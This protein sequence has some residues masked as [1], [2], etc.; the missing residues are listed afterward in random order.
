MKV[1]EHSRG[2]TLGR[3]L[4]E[5]GGIFEP[6]EGDDLGAALAVVLKK[7]GGRGAWWAPGIFKDDVRRGD[8]WRGAWTLGIDGDYYAKGLGHSPPSDDTRKSLVPALANVLAGAL[9]H[10]TPRGFRTVLLLDRCTLDKEEHTKLATAIQRRV[11]RGLADAGVLGVVRRVAGG[12]VVVERDGLIVDTGALFDR[13][14][15]F[16]TPNAAVEGEPLARRAEIVV[17]GG[18]S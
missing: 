3:H 15:L 6:I 13:A 8:R 10:E 9:Y 1:A 2:I 18:A 14:R 17:L 16:F 12:N 7:H 5:P 11:E 4:H